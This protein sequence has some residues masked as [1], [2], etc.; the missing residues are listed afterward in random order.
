MMMEGTTT[1][2]VPSGLIAAWSGSQLP[3]GW[4]LC[5]GTNGTPD[6]RDRFIVG[7]NL[8]GGSAPAE[9]SSGGTVSPQSALPTHSTHASAGSHT[10]A[11]SGSTGTNTAFTVVASGSGAQVPSDGHIHGVGTLATGSAGGHTH[12]AH[13]AHSV[14]QYY[15]L[16]WIMKA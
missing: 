13:S 4:M 5:D 1:G 10:H 7:G 14:Y 3:P 15:V 12:D 16:A 8:A 6:L 2:F 9:G 11:L